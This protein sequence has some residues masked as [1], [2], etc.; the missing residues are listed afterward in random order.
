MRAQ[1]APALA[2]QL[3]AIMFIQVIVVDALLVMKVI[4]VAL[5]HHLATHAI[6]AIRVQIPAATHIA[7]HVNALI[8]TDAQTHAL[9]VAN[10]A[11]HLGM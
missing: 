3:A 6:H 5:V 9:A 8:Q 4:L 2:I 1:I 7:A 11:K 10:I